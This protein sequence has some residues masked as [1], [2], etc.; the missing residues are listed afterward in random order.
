MQS[1]IKEGNREIA[2]IIHQVEIENLKQQKK[3]PATAPVFILLHLLF[4]F[5]ECKETT[6]NP[7]LPLAHKSMKC[8]DWVNLGI[9]I[10]QKQ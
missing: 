8:F 2:E 1:K 4:Y 6:I 5:I 3:F 10:R 9:C 7:A